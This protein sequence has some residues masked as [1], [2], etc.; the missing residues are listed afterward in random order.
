M[1][2][3][4]GHDLAVA[5]WV[6]SQIWFCRE[7]G[8]DENSTAIGVMDGDKAVGGFVF[9]D[10]APEFGVIEI[11][12]AGTDRRWLTRPVIWAMFSYVFNDI[13]CQMCCSRTPASITAGIRFTKAYG[14]KQVTV[15]RLFGRNEDGIISTLTVE[16]WRANGW[17]KEN[18]H[19]QK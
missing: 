15:P 5:R 7:R 8:F 10:Y 18:S 1:Q 4:Y 19:G 14:F 6:A 16:D 2:L 3:I 11:S 9:H 17:H 12:F 13:G